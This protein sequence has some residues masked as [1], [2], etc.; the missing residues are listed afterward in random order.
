MEGFR[1]LQTFLS[2]LEERQKECRLY[3]DQIGDILEKHMAR[4]GVYM[5]GS[6]LFVRRVN[7]DTN[8]LAILCEHWSSHQNSSIIA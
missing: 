8:I 7:I 5:V 2:S 3:V 4:M 6:P 1:L